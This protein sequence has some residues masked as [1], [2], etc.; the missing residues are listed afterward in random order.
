MRPA[1]ELRT[2]RP[3]SPLRRRWRI[4]ILVA[5]GTSVF[6]LTVHR[7]HPIESWLFFRYLRAAALAC[8]FS[9][10]CLIAGHAVVIRVLHRVLPLDEHLAI[11]LPMGV[12]VFFLASFGLGLLGLYGLPFFLLCPCLLIAL[13]ARDFLRA[14]SRLRR[15]AARLDLRMSV[16]PLHGVILLFGCV[17]VLLVWFTI[18]TPQNASYDARWY[19]LPI[20]EHYVAE[21][22]I[23]PFRE[24]WVLGAQPQLA[25]L[26]Y[27]WAFSAGGALFDRVETAAH[28]E[29]AIF[30]M[31]LIGVGAMVRRI[32]GDR[33]RQSWV[34]L[35]LFP[36]IFCY[37]SGL[38]LGADHVAALW[39]A[40]IFLL[41][42]R[43]LETPSKPYALLLGAAVAGP[44]DTKYTAII[45]LPLPLAVVLAHAFPRPGR[46]NAS[47]AWTLPA[48]TA[49][50]A[51]VLTAPHWLKN[52]LFYG[53]P[54]YPLLRRWLPAH[55]WSAAAEAP[56]ATWF[57]LRHPPLSLSGVLEMAKTLVTFSFVPHDFP[58]YH[59]EVPVFGSLFTLCT[60]LLPFVGRRK[61]L[62]LL[63]GAAYLGIAA[64]FWI[65]EFDRYLQVLVPWMAGA[66]AAVLVL[67]WRE[68]GMLRL[69]VALLVGL[70]IVWGSAVP[71]IP[72]HRAAGSA[73]LKVVIDQFGRIDSMNAADRFTSFREWED[74]AGALPP[75]AKVLVHE[76]EIHLGLAAASALDYPGNQGVFYW[77]EPG[78]SSPA[79]VWKRLRAHRVSHVVWANNLD[80]ATDTVAGGLVFFEFVAHHTKRVGTYGGFALAALA[81]TP[82]PDV[83]PGEI[84][85]YPCD[86]DPLFAPGL[87]PLESMARAPGDRRPVAPPIASVSMD[88]ALARAR[89]LVFDAR[90]H[91][92]LPGETRAA[93]ELLAARGQAMMLVRRSIR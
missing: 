49:A 59:G 2:S 50:S 74:L 48:L 16:G 11:A 8:L 32:L 19:H 75:G 28:I 47:S 89:F 36:G 46:P 58:Q 90:C 70:Q 82:P 17:A 22:G 42:L 21:G 61:R 25:S 6:A 5:A 55:P 92:P 43:Y 41:S 68:G 53:D 54:L 18:L 29:F 10:T 57:T 9:M 88:Q 87:Y 91:G 45:L 44:I 26:L 30:L 4:A 73:I 38:V 52:A 40:P 66:T 81:D 20:A 39:A 77:G 13:G 71:F 27:A 65:H 24:G 23:G 69:A 63:F 83:P 56:Y 79:D 34:A 31:T 12:L 84:A 64:W 14:A 86:E 15:H 93:F 80:H 51:L 37:D 76:E 62:Y 78:A 72:S 67:V 1:P 35:F 33:V 3:R 85:Y 60:P 7:H